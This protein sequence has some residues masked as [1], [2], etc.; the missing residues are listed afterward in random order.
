MTYREKELDRIIY[1]IAGACDVACIAG[2]IL[3][4]VSAVIYCADCLPILS[5]VAMISGFASSVTACL[6]GSMISK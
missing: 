5:A 4:T 2:L 3:G 1:R 6:I